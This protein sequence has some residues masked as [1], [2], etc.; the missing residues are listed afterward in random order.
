MKIQELEHI[1]G[2][3][4]PSI[5]F[6]EREGLLNPKRLE[7]GYRD[8][9][10]EDA[11]L[12]KKIKLLRRLGM[13]VERIRELQQGSVEL[14]AVIAGQ[15]RVHDSRIGDHR[16]CRA[17][18]EAIRDD[19]AIFSSLD[20]EHYLQLLREI[21]IDDR[22]LGQANFQEPVE[23]EIHPW[24]RWLARWLDYMLWGIVMDFVWIV[25]LRMRPLP[26]DFGNILFGIAALALYI[27]VEA[28]MLH[29]FG[30]T[31]GKFIMGIRLEYIQ[32]GKLPY[33]DA[34]YRSLRVYVGGVGLGIPVVGLVLYV[35]RYC[36]LTGRSWRIFV[37]HDEIEKP[38]EMSW[39]EETEII[40]NGWSKK[41]GLAAV[42][43]LTVAL[44][45]TAV[46]ILD[47]LKP[48]YR[49]EQLTVAQVAENYN[50]T[51]QILNQN[52]GYYDKLLEDGSKKT[53]AS[54]TVL[55]DW[56]NSFGNH[57]IQFTYDAPNGIVDS[58]QILHSWDQVKMLDSVPPEALIMSYSLLL[59]QKGCGL[60]EL[61]EFSKLYQSQL[62]QKSA[63][64]TYK[65]LQIVWNI[66]TEKEIIQGVIYGDGEENVSVTLE[67]SV[68][69]K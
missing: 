21:R 58:V 24:R 63:V 19:G 37:R 33:A 20:A 2:L 22:V 17:V 64:F 42:L 36:Q 15:I 54:N 47:G 38:R 66:E 6:Y 8:Y 11:Q 25:L 43:F 51:L 10:E 30:T 59:A 67:F 65:N 9:S 53:V 57:Q 41:R 14:N 35:L 29:Q 56:N 50:A 48:R 62:N 55:H 28:L 69:I 44:G 27:P 12:L 31:P 46:N 61:V 7:N 1:T 45:M 52:A 26:G 16:R 18:C 34:L 4:R 32:G 39:D 23:E 40:Y 68:T 3:E 5:R 13:P 60:R 49:G